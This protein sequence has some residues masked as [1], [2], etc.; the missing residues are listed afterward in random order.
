MNR[1]GN[2]CTS[3]EDGSYR[4]QNADGSELW[5]NADGSKYY[6]PG[7]SGKGQAWYQNPYGEKKYLADEMDEEME[8]V[9]Y[10]HVKYEEQSS[11][12]IKYATKQTA[13]RTGVPLKYLEMYQSTHSSPTKTKATVQKSPAKQTP[14]NTPIKSPQKATPKPSPRKSPKT[15]TLRKGA[16]K[17]KEIHVVVEHKKKAPEKPMNV[18]RV[19]HHSKKGDTEIVYKSPAKAAKDG[20]ISKGEKKVVHIHHR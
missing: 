20:R 19:V 7:T 14:K 10:E 6:N 2:H 5:C 13:K 17:E 3:F 1:F 9:K 15:P 12:P 8:D 18:T 11:T 4:Y 16:A